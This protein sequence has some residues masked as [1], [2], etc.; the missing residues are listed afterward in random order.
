MSGSLT[1]NTAEVARLFEKLESFI[2]DMQIIPETSFYRSKVLLA[3]LSKSFTTSRAVCVLG[4]LDTSGSRLGYRLKS[5]GD[6]RGC[7]AVHR[8]LALGISYVFS[9]PDDPA[10]AGFCTMSGSREPGPA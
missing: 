3:L 8:D 4:M 1:L 7:W 6:L 10:A 5:W 9:S 2:N